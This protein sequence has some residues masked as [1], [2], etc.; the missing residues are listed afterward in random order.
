[1]RSA[2]LRDTL[3]ALVAATVIH[4]M[5]VAVALVTGGELTP[6]IAGAALAIAC[7]SWVRGR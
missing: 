1:M 6:M 2:T 4:V 5:L 7:F 3:L